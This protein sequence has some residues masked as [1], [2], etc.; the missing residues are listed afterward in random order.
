ML[1]ATA[2][3]SLR[4]TPPKTVC[5]E[6]FLGQ[7]RNLTFLKKCEKQLKLLIPGIQ[8]NDIGQRNTAI[9]LTA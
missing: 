8:L 2:I 4:F 1:E 3:L 5:F 9:V 6:K 7:V